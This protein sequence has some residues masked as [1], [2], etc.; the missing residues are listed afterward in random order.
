[1]ISKILSAHTDFTTLDYPM[2][3]LNYG[4]NTAVYRNYLLSSLQKKYTKI[5]EKS[6]HINTNKMITQVKIY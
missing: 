1:M 5:T 6:G 2:K 3:S 4:I